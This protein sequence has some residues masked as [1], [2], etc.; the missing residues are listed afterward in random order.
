MDPI[1]VGKAKHHESMKKLKTKSEFSSGFKSGK[2]IESFDDRLNFIKE[3]YHFD[4]GGKRW[5]KM[6][7]LWCISRFKRMMKIIKIKVN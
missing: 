5:R 2:E 4:V 1:L 3:W 7:L 6:R